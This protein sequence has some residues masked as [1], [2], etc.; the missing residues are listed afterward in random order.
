[1]NK[2]KQPFLRQIISHCRDKILNYHLPFS[3]WCANVTKWIKTRVAK[4]LQLVKS[5]TEVSLF[6]NS[7]VVSDCCLQTNRRATWSHVQLRNAEIYASL[8]GE[9]CATAAPTSRDQYWNVLRSCWKGKSFSTFLFSSALI[10][11]SP[12]LL[13]FHTVT[14][15]FLDVNNRKNIVHRVL[16][17][18]MQ[19][20]YTV[21]SK[22]HSILGWQVD[23]WFSSCASA[24]FGIEVMPRINFLKST[25]L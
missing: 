19:T 9:V 12:S 21:V 16:K 3:T 7:H 24:A 10:N 15:A 1:M 17:M 18:P 6:A 23:T 11:T 22:R 14:A 5:H 8:I 20:D 4:C 2:G 13:H 25:H